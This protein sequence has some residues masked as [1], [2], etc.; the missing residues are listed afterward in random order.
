V[1]TGPGGG[2]LLAAGAGRRSRP[3]DLRGGDGR[4]G[5]RLGS[6]HRRAARRLYG[7]P[8]D[9]VE[10]LAGHLA[11]PLVTWQRGRRLTVAAL[12]TGTLAE[13]A[14]E[15]GAV[16]AGWDAV[17]PTARRGWP[18]SAPAAT[19]PSASSSAS[20]TSRVMRARPAMSRADSICQVVSIV[21][22]TSVD[23]AASRRATA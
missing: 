9:A 1:A 7:E 11:L 19:T 6:R 4:R 23:M 21:R 13:V 22:R 3:R 16:L 18:T 15:D 20:P 17:E 12:G 8:G 14:L 10:A 2:Q 5:A